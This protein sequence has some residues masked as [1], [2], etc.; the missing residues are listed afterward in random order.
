MLIKC[1]TDIPAFARSVK[2]EL[3]VTLLEKVWAKVNGGYSNIRNGSP[4]EVL[5][6]FTG[7][8]TERVNHEPF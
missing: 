8:A 1:G 3:W 4:E 5:L 6:A 7:S 2:N